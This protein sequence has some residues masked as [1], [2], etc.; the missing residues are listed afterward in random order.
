MPAARSASRQRDGRG[1]TRERASASGI[2]RG[3]SK[4]RDGSA[5]TGLAGG[6][7]GLGLFP[8]YVAGAVG[9]VVIVDNLGFGFA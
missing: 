5:G 1:G 8:D 7:V 9:S 4:G 2:A 6:G 3:G